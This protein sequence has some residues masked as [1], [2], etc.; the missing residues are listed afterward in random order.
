MWCWLPSLTPPLA[1]PA[2]SPTPS[3]VA[4]C[5]DELWVLDTQTLEWSEPQAEGPVP[6]PRAG[7]AGLGRLGH[8]AALGWGIPWRLPSCAACMC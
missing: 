5:N 8:A 3:T 7:A 2:A 6:P 4:H 1:P